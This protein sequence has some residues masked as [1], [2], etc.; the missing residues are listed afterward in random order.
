[1]QQFPKTLRTE[2]VIFKK[3]NTPAKIQDFLDTIPFNFEPRRSTCRSPREALKHNTAHCLEGA[4]LAAAALWYHGQHP[5]LLDL[6]TPN[7]DTDH[8]VALFKENGHWGALSKTNHAVL[9]Y[10]DPVYK[11]VRELVM[12]Y[13]NEYF[14]DSGAKTLRRYSEPFNMLQF[15]DDW[16][17]SNRDM[18][19]IEDEIIRSPHSTILNKK[20]IHALRRADSVEIEAGKITEYTKPKRK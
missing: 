17:T 6:E 14:I 8:V 3:I 15:E 12:S 2:F 16:L 5:F 1:M 19:N 20:M 10:R 7:N 13:F 4:I 18:W 9:R 11:T